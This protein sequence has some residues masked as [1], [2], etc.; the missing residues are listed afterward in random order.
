MASPPSQPAKGRDGVISTLNV[1]IQA[2]NIAKDACGIPPAQA[3]FGSAGV[4]L[5]MIRVRFPFLCE[6]ELL[7]RVNLG[8]NG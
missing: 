1:F 8:H 5:T 2:L 6:D 3:A 7:T 4:L